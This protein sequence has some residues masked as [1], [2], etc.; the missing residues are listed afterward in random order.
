MLSLFLRNKAMSV[1]LK[2]E[3]QKLQ[4]TL[5]NICWLLNVEIEQTTVSENKMEITD[6][7]KVFS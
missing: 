2:L 7:E 4:I 6:F 5:E 1:P 3:T